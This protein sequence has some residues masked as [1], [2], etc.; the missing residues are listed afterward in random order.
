MDGRALKNLEKC[1]QSI[2]DSLIE[3]SRIAEE[4]IL[5]LQSYIKE[6]EDEVAFWK[7]QANYW[8]KAAK[9]GRR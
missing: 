2:I 4:E 6:L 9:E 1:G 8:L 7:Q 3:M 5:S